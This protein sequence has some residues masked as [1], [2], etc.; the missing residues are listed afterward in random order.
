VWVY[1]V[2]IYIHIPILTRN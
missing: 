2:N 1:R